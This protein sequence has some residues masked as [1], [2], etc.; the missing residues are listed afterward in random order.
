MHTTHNNIIMSIKNQY[1]TPS[2]ALPSY[3][4]LSP[5]FRFHFHAFYPALVL[6]SASK[7]D[8]NMNLSTPSC[9]LPFSTRHSP[10]NR[11]NQG[12]YYRSGRHN[13]GYFYVYI[14]LSL[15]SCIQR[16][17]SIL[18][19]SA[20][21]ANMLPRSTLSL[22]ASFAYFNHMC[23]K[24][25]HPA[26]K[27]KSRFNPG[28]SFGAIDCE[29][30]RTMQRNGSCGSIRR[31]LRTSSILCAKSG[32]RQVEDDRMDNQP[33]KSKRI[34]ARRPIQLQNEQ[35]QS[36]QTI[37]QK[38]SQPQQPKHTMQPKS[39]GNLQPPQI[40]FSNNHLLVVNKPP[41]WK[42]QPGDGGGAS[43]S[44]TSVDP[45]CLLTFLQSQQLGGGSLQNFLNPTHRLDQP[46]TG[47][48]I[49]AKNGKAASRVQV[50]WSKQRVEK[51]YWVVVEGG[52]VMDGGKGKSG[53]TDGLEVLRYQS[54][55]LKE[56]GTHLLSA[57]IQTKPFSGRGSEGGRNSRNRPNSGGVGSVTV[58]PIPPNYNPKDASQS[59]N[60]RVCHIE[61]RHLLTLPPPPTTSSTRDMYIPTRHLL[62]VKTD[63][64]AKHQ[65]RALLALAGETPIAGDLRYGNSLN[66]RGGGR[67]DRPLPDG[68]VALHARS[69]FM[70]T[71]SLGG[72]EFLTDEPFVADIP[73]KWSQ[74]FGVTE[75]D[76][77]GL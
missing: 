34:L 52:S 76:V 41:G 68:S 72:M 17:P 58:K 40:I 6:Y 37:S 31:F 62:S 8:C 54:K 45:K 77:K 53:G 15:I 46:C 33:P 56:K 42:S 61:W 50:A 73:G 4:S 20:K 44:P 35:Q 63:T 2:A 28:F 38:A 18:A 19:K 9:A 30:T 71:V 49:F 32:D 29:G 48:L 7:P 24:I 27:L 21:T 51:E 57:V 43:S 66:S 39:S 47:V 64:G 59:I 1:I 65:V 10:L 75:K 13:R 16:A 26:N 67:V 55:F 60:G 70:P 74:F 22:R 3:P 25:E 12:Q 23:M 5:S 36:P 14:T 69:V 11:R